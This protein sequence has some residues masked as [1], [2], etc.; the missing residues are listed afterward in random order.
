MRGLDP[1]IHRK[2]SDPISMDR[3]VKPGNDEDAIAVDRTAVDRPPPRGQSSCDP[4]T[5]VGR[6]YFM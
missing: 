2:K 6:P 1:R 5:V 3:R 4:L